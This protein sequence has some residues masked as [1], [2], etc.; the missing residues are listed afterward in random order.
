[1]N[2]TGNINFNTEVALASQV[3]RAISHIYLRAPPVD[4]EH[5]RVNL[6]RRGVG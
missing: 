1:M 4:I 3:A 2:G 6:Q 5:S